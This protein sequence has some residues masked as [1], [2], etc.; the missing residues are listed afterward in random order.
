MAPK[1][2]GGGA[3]V[4]SPAAPVHSLERQAA[5]DDPLRRSLAHDGFLSPEASAAL[6]AGSPRPWNGA[7]A[8]RPTWKE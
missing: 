6:P 5:H 1:L 8:P 4:T 7:G 3:R 2:R